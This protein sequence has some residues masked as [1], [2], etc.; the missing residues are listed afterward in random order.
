MIHL[1]IKIGGKIRD[2][3]PHDFVTQ[4]SIQGVIDLVKEL[5]LS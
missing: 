3:Q 1:L 2:I 5:I 4:D